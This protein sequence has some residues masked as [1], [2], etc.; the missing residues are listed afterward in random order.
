MSILR[1]LNDLR[2]KGKGVFN[3][4]EEGFG[5]LLEHFRNFLIELCVSWV[6]DIERVTCG[7]SG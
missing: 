2:G 6:E 4:M 1:V 7:V 3:D 5:E